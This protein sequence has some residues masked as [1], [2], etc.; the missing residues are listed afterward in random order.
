MGNSKK[1]PVRKNRNLMNPE[2]KKRKSIGAKLG[3]G[4]EADM[5]VEQTENIE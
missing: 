1:T 5:Y 4:Y 2:K 3:T